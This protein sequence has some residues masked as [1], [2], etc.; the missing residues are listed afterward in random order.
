MALLGYYCARSGG[1]LGVFDCRRHWYRR[2]CVV[3]VK[4][5]AWPGSVEMD[6]FF[7]AGVIGV[8]MPDVKEL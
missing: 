8:L 4:N 5:R 6:K 2:H 3:Q 7:T 1:S